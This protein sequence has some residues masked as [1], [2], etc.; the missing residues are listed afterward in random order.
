MLANVFVGQWMLAD[1]GGCFWMLVDVFV[2]SN[3]I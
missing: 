2:K 3:E 1:V